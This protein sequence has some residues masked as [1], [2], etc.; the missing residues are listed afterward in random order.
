M[1]WCT[2]GIPPPQC[3]QSRSA[4]TP[5]RL[6]LTARAEKD[7]S[8]VQFTL[9]NGRVVLS[10]FYGFLCTPP[11]NRAM[12]ER[13]TQWHDA[14]AQTPELKLQPT[15]YTVSWVLLLTVCTYTREPTRPYP[16]PQCKSSPWAKGVRP[17]TYRAFFYG[18]FSAHLKSAT[19][20]A[21]LRVSGFRQCSSWADSTC[22]S[23]PVQQLSNRL[24][25]RPQPP[26]TASPSYST[27]S[28]QRREPTTAP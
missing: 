9:Y 11:K 3:A 21:T 6:T 20:T 14:R 1:F 18:P 7:E 22:R 12:S 10:S 27:R 26:T 16:A 23:Q 24:T 4:L 2:R 8:A 25:Q 28:W 13:S 19:P 15:P 5:S 17:Y